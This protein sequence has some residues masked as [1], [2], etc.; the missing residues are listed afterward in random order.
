MGIIGSIFLAGGF[1]ALFVVAV[2]VIAPILS[3]I[4]SIANDHKNKKP[5]FTFK[6]RK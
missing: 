2:A 1:V 6:K 5:V 3:L 4:Q